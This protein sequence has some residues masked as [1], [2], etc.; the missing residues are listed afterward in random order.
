MGSAGAR[1]NP[2]KKR[3]PR[4]RRA[5]VTCRWCPGRWFFRDG[6][7]H[8]FWDYD[9]DWKPELPDGAVRG[10]IRKQVFCCAF[11]HFYYVDITETCIQCHEDFVFSAREQ[12]Y[13][14]ERL[15]FNLYARAVRC[16][17]CRRR[18]RTEKALATALSEAVA[19]VRDDPDDGAALVWL[20]E[21]TAHFAER[22]GEGDLNRA[23]AAA[24]KARK[25]QP[26]LLEALFWEAR[27]QDLAGRR[28]KGRAAMRE[29]LSLAEARGRLRRMVKA[30]RRRLGITRG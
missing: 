6:R 22:R 25:K 1:S 5:S 18:Q 10:D 24:R 27:C 23:I 3:R 9:A 30:A 16:P 14:Y 19:A 7:E 12:K 28:A 21:A 13:W 11:P 2:R 29:F 8:T 26:E 15:Q 20:A 4:S 17:T